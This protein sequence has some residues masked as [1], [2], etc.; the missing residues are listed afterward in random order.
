MRVEAPLEEVTVTVMTVSPTSRLTWWPVVLASAS[1]GSMS[2]SDEPPLCVAVAVT[3]VEEADVV[4]VKPVMAV[5]AAPGVNV[6]SKV[7]PLSDSADR[8]ASAAVRLPSTLWS[9]WVPGESCSS[10]A[11]RPDRALVIDWPVSRLR[12]G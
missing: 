11:S 7:I 6:W 3:V 4:A 2:T 1:A 8:V 9:R 5:P 10:K 12:V